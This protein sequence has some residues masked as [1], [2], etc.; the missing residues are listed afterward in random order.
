MAHSAPTI[1]IIAASFIAVVMMAGSYVLSGPVPFFGNILVANAEN[2]QEL[3]REYA[4]KDTDQDGLLDWQ[5]ALYGTDPN[6][7]ESFKKGVLDGDAVAQGLIQPKVEVAPAPEETDIDSIPGTAA[8]PNSLTDRFAQALFK[9]YMTN[10]GSTP[11]TTD[12]IVSFVEAGVQNLSETSAAPDTYSAKDVK[13]SGETGASAAR[14]YAIAAE[15]AFAENTVPSDQNELVYFGRAIKG[16]NESLKKLKDVAKA[17]E[18]IANALI[19]IPVPDEIAQSH[20][21]IVNALIHMGEMSE[22]MSTMNEDPIRALMGIALYETYGAR[23][24]ASFAGLS[25]V[26]EALQVTPLEG[27][28]GYYII[29]TAR[30]AAAANK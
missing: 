19:K 22:D 5:E 7:A 23:V 13:R 29:K 10:R 17:Y 16:D 26:F 28:E 25:G 4:S 15:Q 21:A 1:R 6:E 9:Q 3:L 14:A 30:D 27:V 12:E 24:V 11:P 2:S 18:N 8:A 20:L